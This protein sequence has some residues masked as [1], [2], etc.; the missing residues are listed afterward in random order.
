[1][2]GWI[3]TFKFCPLSASYGL[4]VVASSLV[5]QRDTVGVVDY[6]QFVI[7]ESIK[8]LASLPW[9]VDMA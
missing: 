2:I 4:V 9:N 1:M 5:L 6:L 3:W 7:L 8:Y